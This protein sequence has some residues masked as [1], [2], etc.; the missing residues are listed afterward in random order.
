MDSDEDEKI[1]F[2]ELEK[3]LENDVAHSAETEELDE[4]IDQI[5]A[6]N[7]NSSVYSPYGSDTDDKNNPDTPSSLGIRTKKINLVDSD[8]DGDTLTLRKQK[9]I[10]DYINN[11][12][13]ES[14]QECQIDT[15]TKIEQNKDKINARQK[16][17]TNADKAKTVTSTTTYAKSYS[18]QPNVI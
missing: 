17:S 15:N 2:N 13:P 1:F 5:K 16:S 4:I 10:R 7:D 3:D 8:E 6:K 9:E 11:S 18:K 14:Q 12:N